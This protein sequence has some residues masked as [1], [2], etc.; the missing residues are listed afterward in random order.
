MGNAAVTA[1]LGTLTILLLP[2]AVAMPSSPLGQLR[3]NL[4]HALLPSVDSIID[5]L[6]FRLFAYCSRCLCCGRLSS[7]C[8]VPH[9]L[10]A[11]AVTRSD[12]VLWWTPAPVIPRNVFHEEEYLVAWRPL[13]KESTTDASENADESAAASRE[14]A[15]WTDLVW[16]EVFMEGVEPADEEGKGQRRTALLQDLPEGGAV[17][18]RI[19]AVS[20]CGRSEWCKEEIEVELLE[21][22]KLTER[23][24]AKGIGRSRLVASDGRLCIQCRT[25]QQTGSPLE[26]AVV[27]C[28]PVIGGRDCPHGPFCSRCRRGVGAQVLPSCVCRGLIDTWREPTPADS[29]G[30]STVVA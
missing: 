23:Q 12:V 9:S 15:Q 16:T 17:R 1:A 18:V 30:L 6:L 10:R 27:A 3:D 29:K 20:R 28:R 21:Q 19:C 22:E 2:N 4:R 25:P 7:P 26:F 24:M 13:K 8:R 5:S 11:Q 14:L